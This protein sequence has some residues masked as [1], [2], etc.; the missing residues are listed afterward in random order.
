MYPEIDFLGAAKTIEK[1]PQVEDLPD[2]IYKSLKYSLE[3]VDEYTLIKKLFSQFF[4]Q[5]KAKIQAFLDNT[6]SQVRSLA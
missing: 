4:G 1:P 3:E 5:K 6:D 2:K